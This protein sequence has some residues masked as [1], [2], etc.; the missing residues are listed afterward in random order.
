MVTLVQAASA[1]E[2]M[3]QANEG[4]RQRAVVAELESLANCLFLQCD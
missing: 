2:A 1:S 4:A 3:L